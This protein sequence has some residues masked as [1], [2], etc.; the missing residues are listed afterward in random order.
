MQ[1]R[2]PVVEDLD[3]MTVV[4]RGILINLFFLYTIAAVLAGLWWYFRPKCSFC[5]N[6]VRLGKGKYH[7]DAE[8]KKVWL[9]SSCEELSKVADCES[10]SFVSSTGV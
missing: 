1:S 9:H 2:V 10:K 4:M 5:G 6:R 7:L 8:Y 3:V